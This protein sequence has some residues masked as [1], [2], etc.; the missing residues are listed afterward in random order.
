M[1]PCRKDLSLFTK[2]LLLLLLLFLFEST[3]QAQ[4]TTTLF[5]YY[6]TSEGLS[7]N[8]VQCIF[9]DSKGFMWFG[10]WNGLNRYDGYDFTLFKRDASHRSLS[11]NF[12]YALEEDHFGNIWIGTDNG[13]NIYFYERDKVT[14]LESQTRNI[15]S[16]VSGRINALMRGKDNLIWV[17]TDSGL[18]V[19]Q[20]LD[21]QG[22]ILVQS[23][24]TAGTEPG[25][26]PGH[27]INTIFQDRDDRIWI[28][29][30]SGL[31]LFDHSTGRFTTFQH[32]P[33]DPLSLSS[34]TVH[35]IYQDRSGSIWVGTYFGLNRMEEAGEFTWFHYNPED[36]AT[37]AHNVVRDITEDL[38]GRLTIA[39]LGGISV[40][41]PQTENFENYK[42]ESANTHYGLNNEFVSCLFADNQGNVWVG[43]E[44]G[45]VNRYN[46]TQK[47]FSFF[48]KGSNGSD[49]LNHNT[50]NAVFEDKQYLWIGT[51]GGG[52][53][54]YDKKDETFRYYTFNQNDSASIGNNFVSAILGASDGHLYVGTWGGGLHRLRRELTESGIFESFPAGTGLQGALPD[55]FVSS[56]AEDGFGNLWVGTSEG[57][58]RLNLETG[59]IEVYSGQVNGQAVSAVGSLQLDKVGNL[60]VGTSS[61]LFQVRADHEGRIHMD[62]SNVRLFLH[63]PDN[64][65]SLPGN[66]V[67]SLHLDSKGDLWLGTYGSGL[68]HLA[69]NPWVPG[70]FRFVQYSEA[71]GLS[72]NVVY[73]IL[74]DDFK[75]LWLTT[76]YGLSKFSKTNGTFKNYYYSDGLRNNQYYWSA[77]YQN[78]EGML[79]VGG[80]NGLNF[81]FPDRLT[82]RTIQ[83]NIVFTDLR[84]N[85]RPVELGRKYNDRVLLEHS[86]LLTDEVVLPYSIKEF[87]IFFSALLFDQPHK[88]QYAFKLD[89]FDSQWTYVD[90]NRRFASFMNLPGGHYTLMVKATDS[91]NNWSSDP[92]MLG[93]RIIPPFYASWWFITS[94]ILLIT[95]T[96][97]G[98]NRYKL[99]IIRVQKKQ[100][101]EK[102][103]LRTSQILSQ[104]ERLQEQA[105]HLKV[106][107]EQLEN[108]RLQIEEQ[109]QQLEFKNDKIQ[110]QRD[111]LVE[112]HKKLHIAN[113]QQLSF[114]TSISH[115][116]RTPLTLILSPLEQLLKNPNIINDGEARSNLGLIQKNAGRLLRLINQLMD[117][118]KI[119]SG[120]KRLKCSRGDIVRFCWEIFL[121]FTPLAEKQKI[122]FSFLAPEPEI[123]ALFDREKVENILFNLL[124]NA[125]KYT[126]EKGK[127]ELKVEIRLHKLPLQTYG[128]LIVDPSRGQGPVLE[129]VVSDSG[130]GMEQKNVRDIFQKFTRLQTPQNNSVRG[131]G[132]GLF[133]IRELVRIHKGSLYVKTSPDEGSVFTVHLPLGPDCYLPEEI[134][135]R[136]SMVLPAGNIQQ[137]QNV[138][139]SDAGDMRRPVTPGTQSGRFSKCSPRILV[140]EDD[141]EMREFI[142]GS[143]GKSF[144]VLH[145]SDGKEGL[146]LA[147]T[148][149]PDLVLSDIMMPGMD[150]LQLCQHLK[151][152]IKTSHIPV[153]LLTAKSD[154]HSLV[155]GL[156]TGADDYVP[157]PFNLEVL[158][159]KIRSTIENRKRLKKVFRTS[160]DPIP[161][162]LVTN[163][164]DMEFLEKTVKLI[165]EHL[166]SPEL[167]V[168]ML[169][170]ELCMSRSLLHKKLTAIAG[171]S[172]NDFIT[173]IR[174]KKSASMLRE[175]KG[176]ITEIAYE[177]GFNDPKY[178][179]RCFKKHFNLSPSEFLNGDVFNQTLHVGLTGWEN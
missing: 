22:N 125:F 142:T 84:L 135:D 41:Q 34:N 63:D 169:A 68:A 110:A 168:K 177:V 138:I 62:D 133:L 11:G 109:K 141:Q 28:G 162:G 154:D 27:H 117:V 100:L 83:P 60:W 153:I 15:E 70:Q 123:I 130:I 42:Y 9:K 163:T 51:A 108:R 65:H 20:V 173:S 8:L 81:F 74:E 134:V 149:M 93:I 12:I 103:R 4:K 118:R 29:S 16:L 58:S 57:L 43:T 131:T 89:G 71:D 176:N 87:S 179:S 3:S 172:T 95:V 128:T 167:N 116:F 99:Y 143:L 80:M 56:L 106:S 175:G 157:K 75:N 144:K 79:Y 31:H 165:E 120:K 126:P 39:T 160:L 50:I 24:H 148:Q 139:A 13:L 178:F 1:K 112:L 122:H 111:K 156:E 38:N 166:S 114:F 52:L 37:I 35:S 32:I 48:D 171:Q 92:A 90:P 121:S 151:N 17:G 91:E 147:T 96:I 170:E 76:D 150:G 102:V 152:D 46:V 174:L 25:E 94:V 40:F 64:P 115:E 59:S 23:R 105:E 155:E 86:L 5:Q 26:L 10:T 127:L 119:E 61:G 53:N 159:A 19:V 145:A 97:I 44:K 2:A 55:A 54:R 47:Q 104:K 129:I 66:F 7:Q 82:E 78:K 85:N 30:N 18:D 161:K 45:G 49:G 136:D 146:D 33:D 88:V 98:Y 21:A 73:G 164:R 124:S 113:Q 36:P 67:I 6:T 72:N 158:E 69:R 132:I 107:L 14:R 77:A 137:Y 101:E 140:V